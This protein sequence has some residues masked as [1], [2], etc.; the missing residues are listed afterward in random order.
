[1]IILISSKIKN[2]QLTDTLYQ[3]VYHLNAFV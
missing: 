1:M 3:F 2:Q